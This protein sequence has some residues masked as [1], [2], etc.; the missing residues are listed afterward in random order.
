MKEFGKKTKTFKVLL[1]IDTSGGFGRKFIKGII[2]FA[3]EN[4]WEIIGAQKGLLRP[5]LMGIEADGAILYYSKTNMK[6]L[7]KNKAVI[8]VGPPDKTS[9]F[10]H[11]KVD[12]E[13]IGIKCAEYYLNKGFRNFAFCHEGKW[14]GNGYIDRIAKAGFGTHIYQQPKVPGWKEERPF[15][16]KWLKS[17]PKP[18]GI[19]ATNDDRAQYIVDASKFAGLAIPEEAAIVGVD[20]DEIICNQTKP[21][22]S[23]MMLN[24]EKAG[25]ESAELLN[26]FMAGSQKMSHQ[27]IMIEPMYV[28]ERQSTDILAIEDKEVV[29]AVKFIIKNVL[30]PIQVSDICNIAAVSRRNLEMRFKNILGRSILEEINRVRVK[31]IIRLL[32]ETDLS[33]LQI[34]LLFKY[35]SHYNICRFFR[36][37]TG[38]SPFE[39]RKQHYYKQ[40]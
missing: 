8:L 2:K 5:D 6:F 35:T 33:I 32:M 31:E 4:P 16:A 19:M 28:V 18:V 26:K 20:N 25:Y 10:P 15:M 30:E 27:E 3:S 7:L 14:R 37:A 1:L 22:L 39:Y 23:S 9:N 17:L 24:M 38:M 21:H 36:N 11:I 29:I 34:A 12:S 40:R 13:T